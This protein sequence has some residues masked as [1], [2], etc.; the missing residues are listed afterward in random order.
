MTQRGRKS[1][2]SL[3]TPKVTVLHP[4]P[5][6]PAELTKAQAEEWRAVVDRMP[7]D[8][9]PRETHPLLVCFVQ[10]VCTTRELERRLQ[11][12]RLTVRD[13]N[14]LRQMLDRERKAIVS[15]ART[16]RLTQ[17]SR[18]TKEKKTGPTGRRPWE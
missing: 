4:R 13:T 2:D 8:W 18:Y 17:R 1:A 6:P 12:K 7:H 3:E 16:M 5:E 14:L 11:S 15:L 10:A 9:F